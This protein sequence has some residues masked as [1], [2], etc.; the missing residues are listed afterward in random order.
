M[1]AAMRPS[2]FSAI[3]AA[4][5]LSLIG[6]EAPAQ[7]P[8]PAPSAIEPAKAAPKAPKKAPAKP[9]PAK[10]P[11]KDAAKSA[12]KAAAKAPAKAPPK[13]YRTGPSELRDK[14]GK[15]IP[16]NPDAYNVDSALPKKK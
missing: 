5:L 7:A 12:P 15:V 14:D 13:V 6:F 3:V 4:A 10:A 2:R 16:T 8:S 1:L 9:D 11:A